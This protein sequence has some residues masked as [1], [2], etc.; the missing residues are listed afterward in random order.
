VCD[1]GK[2]SVKNV[3]LHGLVSLPN[4]GLPARLLGP[5]NG[6]RM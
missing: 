5:C 4:L 2:T 1:R 6:L 3:V